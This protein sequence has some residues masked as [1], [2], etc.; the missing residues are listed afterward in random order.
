[1]GLLFSGIVHPLLWKCHQ[2]PKIKPLSK[3]TLPDLQKKPSSEM[4]K[5]K[6]MATVV[7]GTA[8]SIL[9]GLLVSGNNPGKHTPSS[10]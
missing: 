6:H 7:I 1:M 4:M 2:L 5:N 8:L 9:I 3:T 10:S